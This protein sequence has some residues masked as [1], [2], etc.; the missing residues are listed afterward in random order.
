MHV[1]GDEVVTK[2]WETSKQINEI[3]EWMAKNN[4][5]NF[6]DVERY[7]GLYAQK[8]AI[9]AGKR[10]IVWD[11]SFTNG[12]TLDKNVIVHS[13]RSSEI[14]TKAIKEGYD[15][16]QS[17]GYYLDKQSPICD[18]YCSGIHWLYAQTCKRIIIIKNFT[19][20][21]QTETF[22]QWT[23]WKGWN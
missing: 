14:Y 18:G 3:K 15:V 16:I 2:C 4:L 23:L 22:M 21:L 9:C 6:N 20:S 19:F 1:G 8:V 5:E 10:P 7:F 12:C 13:Y 17:Y 11:D